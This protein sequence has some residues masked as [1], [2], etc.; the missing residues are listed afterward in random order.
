MK[1]FDNGIVKAPKTVKTKLSVRTRDGYLSE[2]IPVGI[3]I[4]TLMSRGIDERRL[5]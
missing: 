2:I 4:I 5:N 3:Y 1:L